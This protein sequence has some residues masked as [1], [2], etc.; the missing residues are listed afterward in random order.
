[1]SAKFPNEQIPK[2]SENFPEKTEA[3]KCLLQT[4]S[5]K[6][7]IITLEQDPNRTLVGQMVGMDETSLFQTLCQEGLD[8]TA[9]DTAV[10]K[11]TQNTCRVEPTCLIFT[12]PVKV[13]DTLILT[14]TNSVSLRYQLKMVPAGILEAQPMEGVMVPEETV[15]ISLTCGLQKQ[16]RPQVVKVMIHVDNEVLCVDVKVVPVCSL[17]TKSSV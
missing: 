5:V 2:D 4:L 16:Q 12:P 3:V 7:I 11:Q 6:D 14:C 13:K 15:I 8:I 9:V 10:G 1:M 17:T